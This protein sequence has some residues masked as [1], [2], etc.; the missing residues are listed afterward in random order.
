[1]RLLEKSREKPKMIDIINLVGNKL[2]NN[3]QDSFLVK[4][5][6][7]WNKVNNRLDN[8]IAV[9]DEYFNFK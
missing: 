1:M 9:V 6:N 2:K 4:T 3:F 5:F 7:K 8:N